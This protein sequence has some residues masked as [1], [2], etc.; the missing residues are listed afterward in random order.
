MTAVSYPAVFHHENPGF[1]VEFP[2]L[3][4]CFAQGN[5][6]EETYEMAMEAMSL[7]LDQTDDIYERSI[8]SPSEMDFVVRDHQNDLVMLITCDSLGYAK[9]F[10]T[11]AI[12]K[13]LTIPEWLNDLAIKNNINFSQ[14]LQDALIEKLC[15]TSVGNKK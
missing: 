13:T 3:P 6:I 1:W 10:K 4:G 14:V 15:P 7:Y 11:K 12:K 2:D 9:R 5:T 8:P